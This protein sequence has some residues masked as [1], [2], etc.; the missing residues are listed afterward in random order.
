VPSNRL[1]PVEK[2]TTRLGRSWATTKTYG[3]DNEFGIEKHVEVPAFAAS[4]FLVSNY[5]FLVFVRAEGYL[6]QRFWSEEGWR[7]VSDMGPTAPRFW[8]N[9]TGEYHLRT[10][11]EEVPMPWDWPVEVCHHEAVAFC[12]YLSEKTGKKLR[13]P[14]EG[15]YMRI[16][17]MEPTDLQDSA[18]GPA[19]DSAPGNVNLAHWASPC[20]VDMFKSPGGLF[21]VLGNVW[22]HNS[23]DIDVLDGFVTHP[24][25]DDFTTPTV[26]G[27]HARIMGGSFISTGADGATRDSRYGF[28]RHFYQ[29]AGFRYV[30]SEH[31]VVNTVSPYEKDHSLCDLFR[32]HFDLPSKGESFQVRLAN[33]LVDVLAQLGREPS[34]TRVLELGCGPGRTT[35]ELVR[36]GLQSVH[37][38]DRTTKSFQG[39][40]RMLQGGKLRWTNY[41]EGEHTHPR[42]VSLTSLGLGNEAVDSSVQFLQIPD[43]ADADTQKY[44]DYDL[45]VMAQPG[46]LGSSDPL[47][48]L[49]SAHRLVRPGGLLALGTQYEWKAA[50]TRAA[51]VSGE[52]V[53]AEVL[54][55]HFEPVARPVDLPFEVARTARMSEVGVQHVT[56]WQRTVAEGGANRSGPGAQGAKPTVA[57]TAAGQGMYDEEDTVGHYLD[58]HYGPQSSYPAECAMLCVKAASELGVPLGRALEVGSGPGRAAIELSKSF[59]EVVAGDFSQSFV[60]LAKGLAQGKEL[61]WCVPVDRTGGRIHQRSVSASDLAMGQ[62]SFSVMDAHTLP[63]NLGT[64]DLVCGFNLIDRLERP[65]EFLAG[66]KPRLNRGGLLVLSSPYTWREEF[67]PKDNWL[68]G[69]KYGDNDGPSSYEGLKDALKAEGFCEARVADDVWFRI[70]ELGN[71]RQGQQTKA[72]VTYWKLV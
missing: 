13:L 43:F 21:D 2:G 26:D 24:L 15:E 16:R 62:V 68:G 66:V 41:L 67:T 56:F 71:G 28:R 42:D 45:V 72:Q 23:T 1:L 14:S 11:T 3:W 17:D 7:W 35:L 19:W 58:F 53:L 18:H 55:P 48:F 69:F 30:E 8:V 39:V 60:D 54:G 46:V 4:E 40:V 51:E 9:R 44:R 36:H 57:S 25:Y 61:Q 37:G 52:E 34:A 50:G 20:P 27:L 65:R 47:R 63:D 5:E 49:A 10:L 31:P 59:K 33:T 29:H 32:F 22:Q 6:T 12:N 64:Y 38:A 70:E